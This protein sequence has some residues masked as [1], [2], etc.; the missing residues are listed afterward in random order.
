MQFVV[1]PST[2]KELESGGPALKGLTDIYRDLEI[3]V[4]LGKDAVFWGVENHGEL[5]SAFDRTIVLVSQAVESSGL[6]SDK[7][8]IAKKIFQETNTFEQFQKDLVSPINR[9]LMLMATTHSRADPI[10]ANTKTNILFAREVP[11]TETYTVTDFDRE[12]KGV[13]IQYKMTAAG[14]E[15]TRLVKEAVEKFTE[16]V[17]PSS[18]EK[19]FVEGVLFESAASFKMNTEIGWPE[20]IVWRDQVNNFTDGSLVERL[21]L[22]ITKVSARP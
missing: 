2:L 3:F 16:R 15:A 6:P 9:L 19:V 1:A 8:E 11:T 20:A 18:N 4:R 7:K 14:D 12:K 10:Q 13:T 22:K 5:K 21:S 17:S